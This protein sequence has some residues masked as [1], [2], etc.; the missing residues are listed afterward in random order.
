M[1]RASLVAGGRI[2]RCHHNLSRLRLGRE[3][4]GRVTERAGI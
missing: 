2:A 1:D 3:S 4:K